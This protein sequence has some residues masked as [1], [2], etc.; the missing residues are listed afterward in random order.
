VRVL[1]DTNIL[2]RFLNAAD[3]DYRIVRSAIDVLLKRRDQCRQ[4]RIWLNQRRGRSPC[5]VNR[6]QILLLSDDYR[7]HTEWRQLLTLNDRD[8][9]RYVGISAVHPR[10]LAAAASD[11]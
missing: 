1:L 4:E 6:E 2:L 9:A 7:I 8:F 11:R 10:D 5:G 3:A